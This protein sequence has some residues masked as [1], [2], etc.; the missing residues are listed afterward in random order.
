MAAENPLANKLSKKK[1]KKL[2][3]ILAIPLMMLTTHFRKT[4]AP[5][6]GSVI[7]RVYIHFDA[8][9]LSE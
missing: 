9:L 7:T 4:K 5:F 1:L 3:H 8:S 2:K 6:T